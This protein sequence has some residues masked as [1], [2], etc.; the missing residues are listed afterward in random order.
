MTFG[1]DTFLQFVLALIMWS[2]GLSLRVRDFSYLRR[3]P[4]LLLAG[5]TAK[6]ILLPMLGYGLLQLTD[7]PIPLQLGTLLLLITP[8]GTTS[9]VITYYFKGVSALTIMLTTLS[10]LLAA[11]TIPL[12][13]KIISQLY[14]GSGI[15]ITLTFWELAPSLFFIIILPVVIGML[16]KAYYPA[17]AASLEDAVRPLSI[18]LLALVYTLKFFFPETQ[19]ATLLWSDIRQ[20][21]PILLTINVSGLFIG[22]SFGKLW[23]YGERA[24]MTIG[25]EMG[26]QNPGLVIFIGSVLL[27]EDALLKPALLYALFSF[28]TTALFAF[29]MKRYRVER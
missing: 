21:F 13:Y 10:T 19:A 2:V 12:F 28:W 14:L 3:Q 6:M 15:V 26:I 20:L 22:W 25:I 17:T 1:V 16:I 29:L 18:V 27:Q 24:S 8:G 11:F 9:N 7:L 4:G 23:G 5:L